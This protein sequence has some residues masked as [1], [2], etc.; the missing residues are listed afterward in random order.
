MTPTIA[1]A[2]QMKQIDDKVLK[3]FGINEKIITSSYNENEWNAFYES[4]IEPIAIQ[5][6]LEF[7]NKLFTATEKNFGNEIIF[8]SN[9]LQYASNETKINMVRY[10]GNIM[11]VNEQREMF[12]LA[13]VEGGD[14]FMIDQ[15]HEIN[16]DVSDNNTNDNNEEG[17]DTNEG[18]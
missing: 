5:M 9:R 12:N 10:C 2:E 8:E 6:S 3:A 11:M 17:N 16:E 4:I 18:N 15:N 13:P 14:V 7:T 1:S